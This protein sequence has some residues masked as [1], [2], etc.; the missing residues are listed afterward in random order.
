MDFIQHHYAFSNIN[1]WTEEGQNVHTML[2]YLMRYM[3]H[4]SFDST[5]YYIHLSPDFYHVY[6]SMSSSLEECIPE[7]EKYEV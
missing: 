3:G 4:S 1:R 7:V 6:T 5:L 2:P